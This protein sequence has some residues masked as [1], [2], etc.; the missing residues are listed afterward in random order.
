VAACNPNLAFESSPT[1]DIVAPT[2]CEGSMLLDSCGSTGGMGFGFGGGIG[3]GGKGLGVG[4]GIGEGGSGSG[5]G[6]GIGCGGNGSTRGNA[7]TESDSARQG[8]A[9]RS[10]NT[11]WAVTAADKA[12]IMRP[13]TVLPKLTCSLAITSIPDGNVSG[14][15]PVVHFWMDLAAQPSLRLSNI[16]ELAMPLVEPRD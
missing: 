5:D 16:E 13:A 10:V 8:N 1:A 7:V 11:R 15:S 4:G 9:M 2:Y 12:T 6:R 3:E 14:T